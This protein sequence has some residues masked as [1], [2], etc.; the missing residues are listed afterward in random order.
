MTVN[1]AVN[2]ITQSDVTIMSFDLLLL[3]LSYGGIV[4]DFFV[5]S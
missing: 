4:V 3:E 2:A 5:V 1:S